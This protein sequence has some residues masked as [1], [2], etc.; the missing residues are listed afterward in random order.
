[1]E[2][3][4]VM[5]IQAL[6]ELVALTLANGNL[7]SI[8]IIQQQRLTQVNALKLVAIRFLGLLMTIPLQLLVMTVTS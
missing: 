8:A 6:M 3:S 2:H 4:N 1:M 7:D 5:E